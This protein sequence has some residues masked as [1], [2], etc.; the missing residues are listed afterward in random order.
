MSTESHLRADSTANWEGLC[1]TFQV[2]LDSRSAEFC[3]VIPL[4]LLVCLR[5][6]W[7]YN[8]SKVNSA[9]ANTYYSHVD[10]KLMLNKDLFVLSFRSELPPF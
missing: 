4:F 2:E 5:R 10:Y 6:R 8:E 1:V 3:N 9:V 7:C